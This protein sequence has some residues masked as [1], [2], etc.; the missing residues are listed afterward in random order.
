MPVVVTR[1]VG[2]RIKIS[3][4]AGVVKIGS[5]MLFEFNLFAELELELRAPSLGL[6]LRSGV[7]GSESGSC[8][9]SG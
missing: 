1:Q 4:K 2:I 3:V 7:S 9:G 6:G 5:V 8:S